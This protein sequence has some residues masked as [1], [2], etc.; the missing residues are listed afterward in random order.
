MAFYEQLLQATAREREQL[1]TLPVIRETLTGEV[2]LCRYHAFLEQAYHHVR[3]TVPLMMSC[4]SRLGDSHPWLMPSLRAYI[5]E[6]I[7]HEQWILNDL[8]A[9]G[10]DDVAARDGEPGYYTELMVA[11][12][13]DSIARRHPLSFFGM[14]LVLEGTSTALATQAAKI[15]QQRL[16][17]PAAAFSYLNSHGELDLDHVQ[18]FA[19]LMDQIECPQE[20]HAIIHAAKR[21]YR[22]YGDVLNTLPQ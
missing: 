8:K 3:H 9:A 13:Y 21:F 22:L 14:V 20:Q 19:Q 12:A 17:L 1:L 2:S 15:I 5:D 16:A 11:Y 7:G 6:E 4:G 10:G 18:Y